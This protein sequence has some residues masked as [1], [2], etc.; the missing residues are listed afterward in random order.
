MNTLIIGNQTAEERRQAI[1]HAV[2]SQEAEPAARLDFDSL[3]DAWL[4]FNSE[5]RAIL[6]VM[7]AAGPLTI[8]QIARRVGREVRAVQT[9]VQLLFLGGVVDRT[10]N[11]R[12][13]LPYENIRFEVTLAGR[14]AA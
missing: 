7:A 14:Q 8:R 1:L 4:L 5:R 10:E 12:V 3:D 6:Q 9:D 13:V 2:R 11:G